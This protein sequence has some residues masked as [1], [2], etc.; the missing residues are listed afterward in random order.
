M[1]DLRKLKWIHDLGVKYLAPLSDTEKDTV[2]LNYYRYMDYHERMSTGSGY[3]P[4]IDIFED[5]I[6][7]FPPANML[8]TFAG[9]LCR[10]LRNTKGRDK[11]DEIIHYFIALEETLSFMLE[12]ANHLGSKDTAFQLKRIMDEIQGDSSR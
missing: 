5:K 11:T 12:V 4:L 7:K 10:K 9:S 1:T 2:L 6:A 3:E 8:G